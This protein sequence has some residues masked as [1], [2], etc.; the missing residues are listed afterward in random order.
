MEKTKHIERYAT[1]HQTAHY[2]TVLKNKLK[3]G[4][5]SATRLTAQFICNSIIKLFQNET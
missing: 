4:P 5:A 1:K 2:I 3:M